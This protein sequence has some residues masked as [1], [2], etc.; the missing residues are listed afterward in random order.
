LVL[1]LENFHWSDPESLNLLS[2]IAHRDKFAQLLIIV[3]LQP[4]EVLRDNHPLLSVQGDLLVH[5]QCAVL[6]LHSITEQG[7]REYL[8]ARFAGERLPADLPPRLA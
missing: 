8:G 5:R 7:M 3:T 2:F 1:V 4:E 6:P